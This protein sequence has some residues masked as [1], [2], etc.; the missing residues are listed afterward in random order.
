MSLRNTYTSYGWLAK[1]F[2]W[3][4]FLG[5]VALYGIGFY[6]G[7]LPVGPDLFAKIGL[8]KSI[9][10]IVLALA[11]FRLV[12]RFINPSPDLPEGMKWYERLGAHGVHIALYGAMLIMPISGW[13]M[14][15][16]ANFPV[17]VFGWFT[18]PNMI[19]PS[20]AAVENLKAF[21]GTMAWVVLGVIVLH[22]AAA[23]KHHFINKDNVFSRMMPFSKE[24]A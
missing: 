8:H 12:W 15:N 1:G 22:V 14:S 4:V 7:T 10:I 24:D 13:A 2:H 16:A 3:V 23:L 17:S 11:V 5:F 9:G 19:E 18:L 20:K 6:M 21:H